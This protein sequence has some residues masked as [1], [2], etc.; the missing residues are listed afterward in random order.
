MSFPLQKIKQKVIVKKSSPCLT[1]TRTIRSSKPMQIRSLNSIRTCIAR[2][3]QSTTTRTRKRTS[4]ESILSLPSISKRMKSTHIESTNN[5]Y[6]SINKFIYSFSKEIN[7]DIK[8]YLQQ[9]LNEDI[10]LFSNTLYRIFSESMISKCDIILPLNKYFHPY[11]VSIKTLLVH[12]HSQSSIF[13]HHFI[14]KLNQIFSSEIK[15]QQ[16]CHSRVKILK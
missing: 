6:D 14:T 9:K 2:C 5:D 3:N 10:L 11:E 12:I 1:S 8:K 4:T 7:D 16:I 15:H 13:Q